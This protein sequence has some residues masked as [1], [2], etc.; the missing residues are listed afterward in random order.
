MNNLNY[1]LLMQKE[2]K[3]LEGKRKKL[4][5]HACCAPCASTCIERL[6]ECFDVTVYF[7]N[8][9]IYGE[10]EYNKRAKEL[11]RFCEI[12]GVKS[13]IEKFNEQEFY[14]QVKGLEAEK[15][16][17][18]RCQKCF[19]LRLNKTAILAK[20]QAYDF[21]A[22]T[23]T[24]SPLKNAKLINE[25]GEKVGDELEIKYLVSDFKKQGGYLRSIELSKE[26]NLYRQ[27]YC[28]CKFSKNQ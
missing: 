22:T 12:V 4:L 11:V 3:K 7:F 5:L 1:D 17:G 19:E 16:G 8:P 18:A 21:F 2:I 25:T 24:L 6:K 10:E 14:G 13:I 26:Y 27:N 28:G 20:E 9:N 15:E 23:L